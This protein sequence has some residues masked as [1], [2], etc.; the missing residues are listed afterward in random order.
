MKQIEKLLINL[1]KGKKEIEYFSK[2]ETNN[3]ENYFQINNLS[4]DSFEDNYIIL[5]ENDIFGEYLNFFYNKN[6]VYGEKMQKS[7][8][9]A[10]VSKISRKYDVE[11]IV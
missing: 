9:K 7:L 4:Y 3:I 1:K 10:I 5:K 6:D 8:I 2:I 11:L